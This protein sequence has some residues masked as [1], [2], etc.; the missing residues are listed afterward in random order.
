MRCRRQTVVVRRPCNLGAAARYRGLLFLGSPPTTASTSSNAPP[1]SAV[2]RA[3]LAYHLLHLF[4]AKR[5]SSRMIDRMAIR[6]YRTKVANRI[7]RRFNADTRNRCQVMDVDQSVNGWS[8]SLR[9]GKATDNATGPIVFDASCSGHWVTLISVHK[10]L[11]R[12]PLRE[13]IIGR[14]LFWNMRSVLGARLKVC[15]LGQKRRLLRRFQV[16]N[17]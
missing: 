2:P 17:I 8:I 16:K 5:W 11:D 12:C 14:Y 1:N 4:Y 3:S 9:Q 7:N 6:T 13:L 15:R 10:H